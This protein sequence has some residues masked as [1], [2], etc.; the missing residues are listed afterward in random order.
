MKKKS[1]IFSN[2]EV[3]LFLVT[4][5]VR[6]IIVF[7]LLEPNS[8]L[9]W[10]P[11]QNDRRG[12][13]LAAGRVVN[14]PEAWS[15]YYLFLGGLYALL[16]PVGLIDYRIQIIVGLNV[17]L[18]AMAVIVFYRILKIFVNR[19]ISFIGGIIFSVYYPAIYLNSLIMSE[20]LFSFT[21]IS[22]VLL[23]TGKPTSK[24]LVT[25]GSLLGISMVIRPLLLAFL[26]LLGMWM[27][28]QKIKTVFMPIIVIIILVSVVN[29][30]IG[31]TPWRLTSV[32]ENG[33]VNFAIAQC[34]FKKIN[35]ST[36]DGDAFWFSPPVFW[37]TNRP[38]I[39]TDIP[40][41][42]QRYYYRMGW[43]CLKREPARLGY[44]LIHIK[45]VFMSTFY[46]NFVNYVW[47]R[48]MFIFWKAIGV[49]L[50]ITLLIFPFVKMNQSQSRVRSLL[51]LLFLSLILAVFW[52]N[53]GEERYL[54][55]YFFILLI[56][57]IV[58]TIQGL[59]G[60]INR[61]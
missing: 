56:S 32:V 20:N 36:A 37:G 61:L 23:L 14:H 27:W 59:R 26:P 8:Y 38:E 10:L 29:S 35:Y 31:K 34:E 44:N 4:I 18:G 47:H 21:L 53:P 2:H 52:E 30:R 16:K 6:G 46:P 22:A 7:Y 57:G 19:K 3:I 45:N 42:N 54:A 9:K 1:K 39:K 55:P 24:R 48:N 15:S 25:A 43:E 50:S 51:I 17:F 5:I 13:D 11:F 40:F 58:V 41:S 33:G 60:T 49:G 12:L 28:R